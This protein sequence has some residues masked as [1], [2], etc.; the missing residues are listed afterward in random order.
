MGLRPLACWDC[1]FESRRGTWMSVSCECCVLSGRVL[2]VGL[3][4]HPQE[5]YRLCC[6]WMCSW[7]FDQKERPSPDNGPKRDR[8]KKLINKLPLSCHFLCFRSGVSE[9]SVVLVDTTSLSCRIPVFW[10]N[11]EL[12]KKNSSATFR[13]WRWWHHV[14]SKRRDQIPSDTASCLRKNVIL[15]FK[16]KPEQKGKKTHLENSLNVALRLNKLE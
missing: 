14:A 3:N 16:F 6:V 15:S 13:P 12:S 7:S 1:A 8:K 5:S 2:C 4:T 10:G 9:D 11:V